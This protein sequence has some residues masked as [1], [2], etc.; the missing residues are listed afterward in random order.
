MSI[1]TKTMFKVLKYCLIIMNALLICGGLMLILASHEIIHANPDFENVGV[2][3]L[4]LSGLISI[5]FSSLGI[6]GAVSKNYTITLIYA[7]LCT[8]ILIM[9]IPTMSFHQIWSFLYLIFVTACAYL[10]A[11]NIKTIKK[12]Q[13]AT[14]SQVDNI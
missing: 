12:E 8:L 11:A 3:V 5:G 7:I 13:Q 4:V 10:Y 2:E 1:S 6:V 14:R 9:S